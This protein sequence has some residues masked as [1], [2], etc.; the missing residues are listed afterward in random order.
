MAK[1]RQ[2]FDKKYEIPNL[3]RAFEVLEYVAKSPKP[4]SFPEILKAFDTGKT[5]MYRIVVSLKNAGFIEY[6]EGEKKFAAAHTTIGIP[7]IAAVQKSE[8]DI[9]IA[10]AS[11][12]IMESLRDSCGETV[13]LGVR[14]QTSCVLV[15]RVSGNDE[16]IFMGNIGMSSPLYPSAQGKAILANYDK[17]QMREIID[18]INAIR[19]SNKVDFYKA[20]PELEMI[21]NQG[22]AVDNEE[23]IR[24]IIS[25]AAPIF[26]ASGKVKG[27]LWVSA[28]SARLEKF[29]EMVKGTKQA[30]TLISKKLGYKK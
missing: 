27:V 22:Y 12:K 14:H 2:R 24:G 26:D 25:A 11:E 5:T 28:P 29:N 19:P 18:K 7:Q 9:D 21:A 10:S 6:L 3:M 30:A 23:Y 20:L 8:P 17:P 16:F 15:K 13:M 4:L 1:Q